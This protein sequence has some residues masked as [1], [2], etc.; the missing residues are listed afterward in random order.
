MANLKTTTV[1][2]NKLS[3]KDSRSYGDLYYSGN[4]KKWYR[5]STGEEL[6]PIALVSNSNGSYRLIRGNPTPQ[7][8][9]LHTDR[10][11]DLAS[12]EN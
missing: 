12:R 4:T 11:R 9:E 2:A 1:T 10:E 8:V 6:S 3:N 5:K 7:K